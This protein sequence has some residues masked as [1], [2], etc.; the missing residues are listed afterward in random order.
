LSEPRIFDPGVSGS[1]AV[2]P[3]PPDR[4]SYSSLK[5]VETCPRR[6]VL[7]RGE[8]P[9]L[10]DRSGYPEVPS[11]AALFGDV[12]HD[13]LEVIVRALANHGCTSASGPEAIA[14][15]KDLGG[16]SEVAK[17]MLAKRLTR[18]ADN[19]R[20]AGEG[21]ERLQDQLEHRIPEAREE[22][23][24]YLHRLTLT[25]RQA[26]GSGSGGGNPRYARDVGSHPEATLEADDLRL[27]GRI[28][29]L[30]VGPA[31]VDITD[32]K[33]GAEDESHLDQLR[34]YAV[35]WDRDSVS[36]PDGAPA[37][38]LTA[39][40]PSREV[41]IDAPDAEHLQTLVD[42]LTTR[43][44]N[45]DDL[46]RSEEP[47]AQLGDHCGFCSVRPLCSA[48]WSTSTD[49][50]TLKRGTW[51]DFEG[52]VVERN[53]IKSWWLSDLSPKENALLLRTTSAHHVFEPGQR[54]RL[55]GLRRDE[56]P[57]SD[58]VVAVLTQTSEVFL[59]TGDGDY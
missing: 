17:T 13:S 44:A 22:I 55:L 3:D 23:Q 28:D 42:T 24:H 39:S 43:V 34:F 26:S 37:G 57:D 11:A 8:Y 46:V 9:G 15:L 52:T 10:W 33:T 12:V 14:V 19:P 18:L 54:L 51:F 50:A 21:R 16:Y 32:Y 25:P 49:T 2:L 20:L 53:G 45:A 6:Y 35:L 58:T 30:T 27:W 29:L 31:Q 36:N 5:A 4:W 41:T 47:S 48:Y 59:V 7:S 38:K 56:D 1:V 40:Y